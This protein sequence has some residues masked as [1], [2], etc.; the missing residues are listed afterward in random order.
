MWFPFP[1]GKPKNVRDLGS[2]FDFQ[3]IT[4]MGR[5]SGVAETE[6]EVAKL[7]LDELNRE[8]WRC[9][10][11]SQYAGSSQARKSFFKR[12]VWLEKTRDKI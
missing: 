2:D 12:L 8:V 4:T 1:R 6:D 3:S 7:S 10:D 9:L 5:R 11:G